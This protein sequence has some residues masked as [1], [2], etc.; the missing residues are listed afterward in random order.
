[1]YQ[2]VLVPLDGSALSESVLPLARSVA[3]AAG[4]TLQLLRAVDYVDSLADAEAEVT[5]LAAAYDA[6]ARV[7][8][9][10]NP[11]DVT[12]ESLKAEPSALLVAATHGRSGLTE[13]IVGSFAL[14]VVRLSGR[15]A[16]LCRPP[17]DPHTPATTAIRTVVVPLDGS[18]FSEQIVPYA[19][20]LARAV[21]APIHVVQVLPAIG[22]PLPADVAESAYVQG[23][24]RDIERQGVATTFETLHGDPAEAISRYAREQPG[25]AIAMTSRARTG[26]ARTILGSTAG[27]CLRRA[28]VP[29]LLLHPPG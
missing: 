22:G 23:R 11:I 20:E 6:T 10:A 4:A 12:L 5:R 26:L 21:A 16:L 1:M 13:E 15:P 9:S 17:G 25:A 18:A 29:I 2:H 14:A 27:G 8:Q 24:A 7:V 19:V 28:G 3:S